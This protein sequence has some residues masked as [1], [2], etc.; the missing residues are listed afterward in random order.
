MAEKFSSCPEENITKGLGHCEERPAPCV[1]SNEKCAVF[2]NSVEKTIPDGSTI[3]VRAERNFMELIFAKFCIV[4]V[5]FMIFL[6]NTK[7]G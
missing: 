5:K 6:I 2:S 1:I 4:P 3:Y 7:L